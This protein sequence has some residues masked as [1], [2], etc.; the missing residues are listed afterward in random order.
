LELIPTLP[1]VAVLG[2]LKNIS[3]D[4]AIQLCEDF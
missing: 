2:F 4:R 1:A 3:R